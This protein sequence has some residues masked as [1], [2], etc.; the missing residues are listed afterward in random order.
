MRMLYS[1]DTITPAGIRAACIF[2][3]AEGLENSRPGV[4]LDGH[5]YVPRADDN[6]LLS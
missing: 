2:G 6:L 5:G 3:L 4:P 1:S